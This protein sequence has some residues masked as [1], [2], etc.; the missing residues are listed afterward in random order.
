MKYKQLV[1]E[2]S[3]WAGI[4]RATV[5]TQAARNV[6]MLFTTCVRADQAVRQAITERKDAVS[7][8]TFIQSLRAKMDASLPQLPPSAAMF[9]TVIENY[10]SHIQQT[11]SASQQPPQQPA[12]ARSLQPSHAYSRESGGAGSAASSATATDTAATPADPAGQANLS[13]SGG[14]KPEARSQPSLAAKVQALSRDYAIL[15]ADQ[16]N[17]G[18][19]RSESLFDAVV[20]ASLARQVSRSQQSSSAALSASSVLTAA[21]STAR[22]YL[23]Q[24]QSAELRGAVRTWIS[25]AYARGDDRVIKI[26]KAMLFAS[27]VLT[28]V[29]E[30]VPQVDPLRGAPAAMV[31]HLAS[32]LQARVGVKVVCVRTSL[33]HAGMSQQH[34]TRMCVC[35]K[36]RL[37]LMQQL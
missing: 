23:V 32:R 8:E 27:G 4:V 2:N 21:V 35:M 9:R 22:M 12:E 13:S 37:A 15:S 19:I 1:Q 34:V 7:V 6:F 24:Q 11:W 25:V 18:M 30:A 31:A 16:A 26:F 5:G 3:M 36:C 17:P 20:R 10:V 29:H 28:D 33:H 14:E